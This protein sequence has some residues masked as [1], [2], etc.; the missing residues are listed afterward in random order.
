MKFFLHSAALLSCD[1]FGMSDEQS[2]SAHK[3]MWKITSSVFIVFLV[4]LRTRL[5]RAI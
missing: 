4:F 5:K 1:F 2:H 3:L